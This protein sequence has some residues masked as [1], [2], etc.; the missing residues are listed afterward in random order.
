MQ[1]HI[2]AAAVAA[3]LGFTVS[4]CVLA[5]RAARDERLRAERAGTPWVQPRTERARPPLAA[6]PGW[7]ELLRHAL[8]ANGDLEAAYHE[9][10]AAL[11][12][13]DV[14]AA[15]PNTNLSLEYEYLFSDEKLKSWD[16]NTFVLGFDP[17]QNLSFPT[18]ALAAGR[19]ALAEAQAAGDRFLAAKLALQRDVLVA[20]YDVALAAERLRLER[21]NGALAG[22]V[23]DLALVRSATDASQT[24]T[25]EA[26][27]E[28]ARAEDRIRTLETELRAGQAR[29]NALAGRTPEAPIALPGSLPEAR[30]LPDDAAV[31]EAGVRNNPEL[32]ALGHDRNARTRAIA[33]ARQEFIPDVNPFVGIE[34]GM[35]QLVGVAVSLPARVSMIRG[36][37]AQARIMEARAAAL[38][39]QG[40]HDRAAEFVATLAALRDA[41]RRTGLYRDVIVP[42]TAQLVAGTRAA[43]EGGD[44][45]LAALVEAERL[46]L[47][48][49]GMLAEARVERERRLA[50]LEAVGGF[51]AETLAPRTTEEHS[52]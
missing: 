36:Q 27:I 41:E 18:K 1:R 32:A 15:Y 6:A 31:L 44:A 46:S 48:T 34:G 28:R 3:V 16:R 47:E 50:E 14:A 10:R 24:A 19:T 42:Q 25:I 21:E 40:G 51:D 17:M 29:L 49:R 38:E 2:H 35:A 39:A 37:I 12:G 9:W 33:A 22:L 7:R 8:L 43:Y 11:A 4:G 52:S 45:D 26:T 23:Q 5:P 20:W 13:I 30:T